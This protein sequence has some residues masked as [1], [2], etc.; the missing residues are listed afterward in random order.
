M[1]NKFPDAFMTNLSLAVGQ[2]VLDWA[3]VEQNLDMC[4]AVI[5]HTAGGKHIDPV[6]PRSVKRK[7]RF[8]KLCFKTIDTLAPF[9]EQALPML[10]EAKTL[11]HA[12]HTVVHGVLSDYD[13]PTGTVT[14]VM[15]DAKPEL[16]HVVRRKLDFLQMLSAGEKCRTLT[17]QL[18]D[19]TQCL[20]DTFMPEDKDG[21]LPRPIMG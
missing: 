2:L 6:L 1:A 13:D 12:R 8:L 16:H 7:V 18:R 5:Y 9:K 4:I 10:S 14:F 11:A 20:L 3:F 15:L 17:F 19:L 21:Y